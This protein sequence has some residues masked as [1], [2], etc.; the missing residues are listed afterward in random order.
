MRSEWVG[1]LERAV[2]T[3]TI[4]LPADV[5][6]ALRSALGRET[7]ELARLHLETLLENERVA[8]ENGLPICQDTGTPV[9]FVRAGAASPWLAD[10]A[11]ALADAVRM[12]TDSVPLRPSAIHPF[13][14][15]NVGNVGRSVPVVDWEIVPGREI[16]IV[17]VAKGGGSE[18][19]SG[20]LFVQPGCG[21]QAIEKAVLSHVARV[22]PRACPPVVVGVGIGGTA[23]LALRLAKR[24]LVRRL[25]VH[26]AD[27]SVA[28]FERH[29]LDAINATGIGPAGLGGL[30]T[31]LAVHAEFA[32]RHPASLPIG[33]ALQCWADRRAAIRIHEDGSAEAVE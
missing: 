8:R 32:F 9:F 10:L 14:D 3:A 13:T 5:V 25:D 27:P 30:T 15:E 31:A 4:V 22:A 20:L 6:D 33:V 7:S 17:Y 24:S 28:A 21:M 1:V 29:L 11:D 26:H 18:N 16:E 12:A 23:D 19:A 2:R